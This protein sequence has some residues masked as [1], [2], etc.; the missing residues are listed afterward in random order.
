MQ[1]PGGTVFQAEGTASA[2][3]W[4][5]KD[6]W[7]VPGPAASQRE[8]GRKRLAWVGQVVGR[9]SCR[10]SR[11][12]LRCGFSWVCGAPLEGSE[13]MNGSQA[14]FLIHSAITS[15]KLFSN[16]QDIEQGCRTLLP[17]LSAWLLWKEV[18]RTLRGIM[19][20]GWRCQLVGG[21]KPSWQEGEQMRERRGRRMVQQSGH[22]D[23]Q[24]WVKCGQEVHCGC[25]KVASP[26]Y[27][28]PKTW[29]SA[30]RPT[31]GV[32]VIQRG[33]RARNW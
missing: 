8:P 1:L 10:A 11:L 5:Q 27:T 14:G 21:R 9:G 22:A 18:W 2:K 29:H 12:W 25:P 7:H 23:S 31:D 30:G 6:N 16:E 32:P 26:S 28:T 24:R 3:A 4:R 33:E 19:L 15:G 13:Q 20:L 17:S